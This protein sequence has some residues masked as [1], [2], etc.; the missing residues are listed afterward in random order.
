MNG[1]TL[2]FQGRRDSQ[3]FIDN[4]Q[5]STPE[6]SSRLINTFKL[7]NEATWHRFVIGA[8]NHPITWW[9][10]LLQVQMQLGLW[11]STRKAQAQIVANQLSQ[12]LN[13]AK[14]NVTKD[15]LYKALIYNLRHRKAD[16]LGRFAGGVFTNYASLGGRA[17][18]KKLSKNITR[19]ISLSN[20]LLASYGASI[21]SVAGGHKRIEH[22]VQSVLTG[23][24]NGPVPYPAAKDYSLSKKELEIFEDS[25]EVL[26]E[27]N[28]LTTLSPRPLS[29]SEFCLKPE[30]V[31]LEG[32]CK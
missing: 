15:M 20:F 19:S 29:I 7:A 18:N 21:R 16:V 2:D 12:T 11:G 1:I 31:N 9:M 17:G 10:G 5:S 22:V 32:L 14:D 30:N 13:L 4:L 28:G 26:N 24:P 8:Y 25:E 23:R 3:I 6:Q 27:M